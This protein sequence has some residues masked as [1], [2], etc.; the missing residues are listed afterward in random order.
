[1][2]STHFRPARHIGSRKRLGLLGIWAMA[3]AA[4]YSLADNGVGGWQSGSGN[5]WP[6][7]PIH[8]T[9][10]PDG[11]VVTYG[12][13]GGGSLIY[14]V[15]DPASGFAGGHITL[16][17]QTQTDIF[18]GAQVVLPQ[19]GSIFLAGGKLLNAPNFTGTPATNLFDYTNNT[20]TRGNDLNRPRWYSTTTTLVNG[21]VYIQGGKGG[22]DFPEVRDT[23]GTFRLLT[24]A[25]TTA[26]FWDYPRDFVAPDGRVFGYDN[27]GSM[28][29]VATRGLGSVAGAGKLP[30]TYTSLTASAVMYQPGKILQFGGKWNGALVIDLTSKTPSWHLTGNLSSIR[31]WVNGTVLADGRVLATGGSAVTNTLTGVNN[32]AE[33]WDPATGT[34]VVGASGATPRLYHSTALLLPD[35][36]VLVGGGGHPGPLTNL[37]AEI[38]YPPY[39]YTSAGVFAARPSI[40]IAPD[41]LEIG[42]NFTMNVTASAVSR[43][44]LVKTGAVTHSFN[45][46]QRFLE[47]PFTATSS[48]LSVLAPTRASDAPPGYYLLFAIDSS[49]VPS[50]GKIIKINIQSDSQAPTPPT[51]PALTMPSGKPNLSWD[52]STDN[53]GVAGYIIN[54]STDGTAGPEVGRTP[55]GPWADST[56][57]A[58]TTYTYQIEAYDVAGNVSAASS[59]S[60]VTVYR[61]PVNLTA[62]LV[63]AHPL[64]SWSKSTDVGVSG[65]SV[66]RSS[67]GT[68]GSKVASTST[69]QWSDMNTTTGVTYT[70]GVSA[71]DTG[72]RSSAP[73][74]LVSLTVP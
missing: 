27:R 10:T 73:S 70:Y 52:P 18:C 37:N 74:A 49:G 38:Y 57:T 54:R 5:N 12:N 17:N 68:L 63:N 13:K 69:N 34:W 7:I 58:G 31:Q 72:G 45:M 64:L 1:M 11:R 35:A 32:A 42:Q 48:T 51:N 2:L 6:L 8:A 39:L 41:T 15:W 9:L 67:N 59:P 29:Y 36:S 61:A 22:A 20:L 46:D 25:P 14:D 3:G 26:Y 47:L 23:S 65:Y 40:D 43:V 30:P 33:I 24:G 16:P 53:I 4:T 71:N 44:T 62:N 19:S 60:T 28:Y 66:Y 55:A 21:E 56:V 50:I